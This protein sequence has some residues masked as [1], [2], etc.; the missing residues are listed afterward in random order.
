MP[1]LPD[2]V[3]FMN[4]DYALTLDSTLP[5]DTYTLKYEDEMGALSEYANICSL[6]AGQTYS[7]LIAQNAAPQTATKIGVYNA[8]GTRVGSI[9]L[10]TSFRKDLGDKLYSFGAISDT[11]IGYDTAEDDL[12]NA[13]SYFDKDASIAFVANCGDLA[14]GGADAN[15]HTYKSIVERYSKP[16]YEIAG[17]H[18]ANRG[19]L[20]MD[21]LK[22]FTGEDLYYSFTQGNDVYIMVGMYDVHAG[23]QFSEEELKWL[24]ETLEANRDKR[25]FVF[26]HLNPRDGSGDAV[27]LDLEGDMLSNNRGETFYSLMDHY[28][29]VIWFHGH[30]HEKFEAQELAAMNTYDNVLGSHSVHIPSLSVP[31]DTEGMVLTDDTAASEGYVVDVYENAIVLRGRDFVGGKFLPVAT[32]CLDTTIKTVAADAYKDDAQ[33][34][35]NANSNILK[36]ADTWYESSISKSAISR[37]IIG[38]DVAPKYYSECWDASISG[39]GRIMVY[40]DGTELYIVCG[41]DGIL[42]NKNSQKLFAGFT[43]LNEIVGL[44]KINTKNVVEFTSAFE[45]CKKL[46]ELDISSFDLKYVINLRGVFKGCASLTSVILPENIG[47]SATGG[48]IYILQ[49]LFEECKALTSVDVSMLLNKPANISNIF[50]DCIALEK[51]TFGEMQVTAA[52]NAFYNCGKLKTIDLHNVDFSA[53]DTM[54][55]M[56]QGCASLTLDCSE[57]DTTKCEDIT[58][59]NNGAPGVTP[60]IMKG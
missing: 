35:I 5:A 33:N 55:Q 38:E 51:V 24:Y 11:H 50:K 46:K 26:M 8:S 28:E 53:C 34:I 6:E 13:L 57:W 21:G 54:L 23:E 31:R 41:A 56:F 12:E 59:F 43:G 4:Y 49:G 10:V 36:E 52:A 47:I 18:E 15:L 3:G 16:V 20:A 7:G 37:I 22:A 42:A 9:A 45:N 58:N 39:N 25:C 14:T 2:S 17:N 1:D 40:R 48:N 60:P 19:Y 27:N 44:E 29:N 30:T 32:F